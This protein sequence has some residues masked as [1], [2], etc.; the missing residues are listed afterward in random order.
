MR[1]FHTTA[2]V[3]ADGLIYQVTRSRRVTGGYTEVTA[4]HDRKWLQGLFNTVTGKLLGGAW[5]D[6]DSHETP[7]CFDARWE[8]K[9]CDHMSASAE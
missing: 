5:R 3:Q 6:Y 7:C 2:T 4:R 9:R 8:G 1:Y